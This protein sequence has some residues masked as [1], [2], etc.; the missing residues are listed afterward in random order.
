METQL[1][2]LEKDL[3]R[4]REEVKALPEARRLDRL[5]AEIAGLRAEIKA[6]E[7]SAEEAVKDKLEAQDKR[8]A[9]QDKRIEDLSLVLADGAN[10]IAASSNAISSASNTTNWVMGG[11]SI[12]LTL[13]FGAVGFYTGFRVPSEIRLEA[14]EMNYNAILEAKDQAANAA[15]KSAAEWFKNQAEPRL[16]IIEVLAERQRD[17]HSGAIEEILERIESYSRDSNPRSPEQPLNLRL[18][19]QEQS[20]DEYIDS[21]TPATRTANEWY[22]QI[23]KLVDQ[24]SYEAAVTLVEEWLTTPTI[25]SKQTAQALM[26]K[27]SIF[28]DSELWSKGISVCQD[29]INRFDKHSDVSFRKSVAIAI[30]CKGFFLEQINQK[31]SGNQIAVYDELIQRFIGDSEPGIRHAVAWAFYRK[32]TAMIELSSPDEARTTF[33][34]YLRRFTDASEPAIQE[35]SDK[36]RALLAKLPPSEPPTP[37]DS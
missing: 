30:L 7:K 35:I 10:K 37:A 12:L 25:T 27:I 2:Y 15:E 22:A 3:D 29:V 33:E 4:L 26:K 6:A 13:V 34:E 21:L 23:Q 9:A 28:W 8:I 31:E 32:A 17:E 11:I 1:R 19:P 24:K 14:K 16:K 36:V 20:T 5:E 18:T